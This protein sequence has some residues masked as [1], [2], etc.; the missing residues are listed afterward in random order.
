[1][2]GSLKKV[3]Q[4]LCLCGS[5]QDDPS[6][7]P[8]PRIPLPQQPLQR[9]SR[10][11]GPDPSTVMRPTT[12]IPRPRTSIPRPPTS[13][14]ALETAP[15]STEIPEKGPDELDQAQA[16]AQVQAQAPPPPA[17]NQFFA[18]IPDL[19]PTIRIVSQGSPTPPSP[20]I[21]DDQF[22]SAHSIADSAS[23]DSET[24]PTTAASSNANT[25]ISASSESTLGYIPDDPPVKPA[26]LFVRKAS[27][28]NAL[29]AKAPPV[30]TPPMG[31][32]SFQRPKTASRALSPPPPGVVL[33]PTYTTAEG[34][35]SFAS[36]E[37]PQTRAY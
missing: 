33:N 3:M 15:S 10:A 2:P 11:P 20:L 28:A 21:I 4:K 16:Q 31:P 8:P 6:D 17:E 37:R 18:Y 26:P 13:T 34:W 24:R 32:H 19:A 7:Q 1:M 23:M 36:V 27:A 5:R 30:K 35:T 29:P 9:A 25:P 22:G 12:A 14:P